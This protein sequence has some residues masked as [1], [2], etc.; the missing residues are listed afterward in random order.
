MHA[1]EIAD[2]TGIWEKEKGCANIQDHGVWRMCGDDKNTQMN[3]QYCMDKRRCK[4]RSMEQDTS[5]AKGLRESLAVRPAYIDGRP[6]RQHCVADEAVGEKTHLSRIASCQRCNF[7]TSLTW[8]PKIRGRYRSALSA[9]VAVFMASPRPSAPSTSSSRGRPRRRGSST[10]APVPG[11]MPT[12]ARE[13]SV[14][15][16][17][18]GSRAG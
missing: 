16:L 3:I 5:R 17:L 13:G 1:V 14:G 12:A 6:R 9:T 11:T 15:P 10:V 7:A 4:D 18:G 8:K 2:I